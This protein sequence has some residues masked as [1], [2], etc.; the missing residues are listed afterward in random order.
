MVPWCGHHP[1]FE[2][3]K[4]K[5]LLVIN[6]CRCRRT[7]RVTKKSRSSQ[8]GGVKSSRLVMVKLQIRWRQRFA[9]SRD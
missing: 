1:V 3:W 9:V 7:R 6:E 4:M 2:E 5:S 8:G